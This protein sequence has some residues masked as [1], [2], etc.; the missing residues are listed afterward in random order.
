MALVLVLS[1]GARLKDVYTFVL[2]SL[3]VNWLL[4]ILG[5]T[6]VNF[7]QS[8]IVSPGKAF[9]MHG[10]TPEQPWRLCTAFGHPTQIGVVAAAAAVGLLARTR[11]GDWKKN[12]PWIAFFA[13]TA[14]LTVSRTCIAGMVLGI[15]LVVLVRRDLWPVSL[16]ATA[17]LLP[18]LMMPE[19]D[20]AVVKFPPPGA[21]AI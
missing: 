16:A 6:G 1:L 4:V 2:V 12:G 9:L 3:G 20:A 5:I 21:N 13:I 14:V 11:R 7:G 19:F 8:W 18:L 15:L 17:V 10:E